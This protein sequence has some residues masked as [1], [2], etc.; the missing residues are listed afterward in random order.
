MTNGA[1]ARSGHS[2]DRNPLT[3]LLQE[4]RSKVSKSQAQIARDSWLDESYVSR[5][6]SGERTNPTRDALILLAGFGL[7]LSV[8][9]TSEVLLA[10]DYKDLILP[11]SLK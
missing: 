3:G 8:P 9:D 4:F 7:G 1:L 5:L 10:A 11:Q 2:A 6:F